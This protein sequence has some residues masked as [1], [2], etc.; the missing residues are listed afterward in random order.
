MSGPATVAA[1]IR[2]ASIQ[3]SAC[4]Q[5]ATR[6]W[7][8]VIRAPANDQLAIWAAGTH[9][10]ACSQVATREAVIRAPAN[11]ELAFRLEPAHR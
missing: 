3:G 9:G 10:W 11:G 7:E 1:A 6:T 8:A 4:S 2:A 5:P